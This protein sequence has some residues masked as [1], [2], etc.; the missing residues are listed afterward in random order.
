MNGPTAATL[1]LVPTALSLRAIGP[2]L[3]DCTRDLDPAAAQPVLSRM[4][5][6]VHES[7]MNV[8]DHAELTDG[9][10]IELCLALGPRDLTVRVRDPGTAFDPG[11]VPEPARGHLQERGF[12]VGIVRALVDELTYRRSGSHNELVLRID[13]ED[14]R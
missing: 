8:V 4:E 9:D 12:G 13:L 7:C 14:P 10:T 3:R 1:D 2:W 11:T 5:L 6:A